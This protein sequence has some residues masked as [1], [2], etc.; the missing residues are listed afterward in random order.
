MVQSMLAARRR[1]LHRGSSITAGGWKVT[2]Q[3]T[4][5]DSWNERGTKPEPSERE[6]GKVQV[7]TFHIR[8]LG[9]TFSAHL[10]NREND[11]DIRPP[12]DIT[13]RSL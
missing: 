11:R 3:R 2:E 10:T 5:K 12:H 6:T 4:S 8:R 13:I 9:T 7:S 1:N